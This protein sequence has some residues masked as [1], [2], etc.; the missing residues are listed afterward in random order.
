[1]AD[2]SA[3]STALEIGYVLLIP[4]ILFNL[5][6]SVRLLFYGGLGPLQKT[7]QLLIIWGVPLIGGLLVNSINFPRYQ[8]PTT[9][10]LSDRVAKPP[11]IGSAGS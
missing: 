3:I 8:P 7:I 9:Y 5:V 4:L 6:I 11:G 1:M 10:D 2:Q